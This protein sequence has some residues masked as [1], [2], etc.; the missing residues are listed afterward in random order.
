VTRPLS[1]AVALILL[2]IPAA[3]VAQTVRPAPRALERPVPNPITV[4][5]A[6]RRAVA[7]GTRTAEGVPG[8]RYWQQWSRYTISAR[9]DAEA[10]QLTGTTRIVYRNASP[11]T[12]RQLW[13]QVLQNWHRPEAP[14]HTSAEMTGGYT[15]TRVAAQGQ[16]LQPPADMNRISGPTYV[17]LGTNL[18]VLPPAPVAPGD[19]AV[20]EFEWS[21]KVPQRGIGGRMGWNGD[22]LFYLGYFYPQMAV[23]DD[24]VGWQRDDFLGAGEFYAGFADYDVTLDVPEGWLVQ[25]TGRLLNENEVFPDPIIGRLRAAEASDTVVHVLTEGD[26]GP[27]KATRT[28]ADGRLRWHFAADSVRDVA[29]SVTRAS[30]WDAVRTRVGER[31]GQPRYARAEAI[32]RPS[33]PRWAQGA[34]YAQHAI[35]FHSRH[36]GVTYPYPRATAV[37]GDGIIGGGMEFPMMT[38]ISSY[39]QASDTALYTVVAH[40]L[41]HIW[42]PMIVDVDERR[43]GWMDEGTTDFNEIAAAADFYPGFDEWPD[44]MATYTNA[45]AAGNES[46]LMR[47]SDFLDSPS[48]YGVYG[49]QK[50]STLLHALQGLLGDSVFTRVYQGYLRAWA[51]H[52]PKPWDFFA[53]F[54]HASGRDLG[55]FWRT[56]YYE[57]WTLD[58]A[59]AGVTP[60]PR[61]TAIAVRD[62]GD[63]PMPARLTIVLAD[64]DTLRREVPVASWLAGTRSATV[65]VPRGPAVVSVEI[66]ARHEFPDVSRKNNFWS[67]AVDSLPASLPVAVRADLVRTGLPL[68]R[69]GYRPVGDVLHGTLG[70]RG[71]GSAT[72]TLEAGVRYAFR[73]VCDGD[74]SDIDLQLVDPSGQRLANDNRDDDTP[75]L[76]FTAPAAGA[77]QVNVAMFRCQTA[78]CVWGAQLYRR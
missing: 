74:C 76:E 11:D 62:V 51:F 68:R 30:R 72:L 57:T 44:E 27:G 19:S 47:Y 25:G 48:D 17:E 22:D 69:Q 40:E 46:P 55:W 35:A 60:G 39:D 71:N 45:A 61:G 75:L 36:T 38:M 32:W 10:K 16:A 7:L 65:T 6:Y 23:Y 54:D 4:P 5:Q 77:Y 50:P 14:R 63:A 15:F 8:P 3:G 49:Y 56:W 21:F 31:G 34:R 73:A 41:A 43:Y 66:D 26:F 20:L 33:H 53:Y 42:V 1:A 13:V 52:Q 12:L 2:S 64:G 59:V 9:L 70:A 18:V 37:E 58:Q 24:V 28:G 67:P 78:S 29:Y